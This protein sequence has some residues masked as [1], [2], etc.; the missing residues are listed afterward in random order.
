MRVGFGYDLHPLVDDRPLI[1]GGVQIPYE[2]GLDGHSDADVLCH[3]IADALLGAASLGDIGEHFPDTDPKYKDAV[4]LLILGKVSEIIKESHY[5]IINVDSTIVLEKP[6]IFPYKKKMIKNIAEALR[7]NIEKVSVKATTN[8]KCDAT[9]RGEAIV[10]Y[11]V[12]NLGV[13]S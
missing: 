7:V 4:S 11:A 2:K 3:A 9:G 12:A 13:T 6:R 5:S 8:E 1:L 10:A